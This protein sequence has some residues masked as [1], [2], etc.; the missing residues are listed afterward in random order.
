MKKLTRW[1]VCGALLLLVATTA[2]IIFAPVRLP[3]HLQVVSHHPTTIIQFGND[4][5]R[6][7]NF[8]Y[9]TEVKSNGTWVNTS[10]QPKGARAANN[11][12][13]HSIR[14]FEIAPTPADASAWRVGVGCNCAGG[15]WYFRLAERFGLLKNYRAHYF[16]KKYVYTEFT[17]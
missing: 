12:K 13:P 6:E 10:L 17:Q 16:D 7:L 2:V 11:V 14:E 9:F 15:P 3:L 1:I 4:T 5:G 8:F